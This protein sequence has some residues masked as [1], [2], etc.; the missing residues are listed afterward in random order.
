MRLKNF[1]QYYGEHTLNFAT[2]EKCNVTV[3]KGINGAGKTSLFMALNWCLYGDAFF[4]EDIGELVNKRAR[5]EVENGNSLSTSSIIQKVL[6]SGTKVD[7]ESL[8]TLVE[9]G[10]IFQ[11]TQYFAI[12]QY[13][14]H[15]DGK[16]SFSVKKHDEHDPYYDSAA[17]ELIELIIPANVSEHFFFDGEKID[18]FAKPGKKKVEEAVRNV[19]KIEVFERSVKH[20]GDVARKYQDERKKYASNNL[21]ALFAEKEEKEKASYDLS[22][23]IKLKRQELEKA[24]KQLQDID[25]KLEKIEV[26]REL[27]DERKNLE[28]EVKKME[29]DRLSLQNEDIRNLLNQSSIPLAKP[30]LDTALESLSTTERS[31]GI[32]K[33]ILE[34]L[35]QEMCCLCGREIDHASPEYQNIQNLVSQ[36]VSPNLEFAIRDTESS[37]KRLISNSVKNIPESLQSALNKDT[38][39]RR[40]IDENEARIDEISKELV[41]F[42]EEEVSQL[43]KARTKYDNDISEL[44]YTILRIEVRMQTIKEDIIKLNEKIGKENA[45]GQKEKQLQR[46]WKLATE[47]SSAMETLYEYFLYDKR[48]E[49]ETEVQKVFNQLVWKES[50]FPNIRL[51]EEYELQVI[52]RFGKQARPEMSAGERQVLSLAFIAAMAKVAVGKMLPEMKYEPFPMV[53][54][55]PFGRLSTQHRE[56][57]TQTIPGITEQLVLFVTDEELRDKARLNLEPRIGAEYEL[58]F[59]DDS[60]TTAIE[61]V[62]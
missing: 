14:W 39:I 9:I 27:T 28:D 59:D 8:H 18:N 37:L 32:P 56:N 6:D 13:E 53:M 24:E 2:D 3:I 52:D 43:E 29:H 58:Q 46:Y 44:K 17:S 21:K 50:Q 16:T 33:P 10:F 48:E 22:V 31:S 35:I 55:T 20:L 30:V 15:R 42:D 40:E 60:G 57:I 36:A 41:N 34:K 11:S 7:V 47:S 61:K 5:K 19:L 51:S 49:I 62:Q 45:K 23:E 38:K 54:D 26:A 25:E 1:R 4:K 12:R